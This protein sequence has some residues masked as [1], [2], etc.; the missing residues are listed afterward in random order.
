MLIPPVEV[1]H[2]FLTIHIQLQPE[3]NKNDIMNMLN[4][5]EEYIFS[6]EIETEKYIIYYNIPIDTDISELIILLDEILDKF[7]KT[8]YVLTIKDKTK[9]YPSSIRINKKRK[10]IITKQQK[11]SIGSI[12]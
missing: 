5:F 10:K 3:I 12:Y 7:P 1:E 6:D 8:R 4:H 9:K 11:R 2:I